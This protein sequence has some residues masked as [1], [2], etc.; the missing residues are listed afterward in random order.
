[1]V[2]KD[3]NNISLEIILNILKKAE[4]H[5]RNIAKD[6]N[7]SHT[8]ILRKTKELVDE[9]VLDYKKQGKNKVF[10]LK[11]TLKAKNY[12]FMAENYKT[13]KVLREY[14]PLGVI[15][16]DV[17]NNAEADLIILFGSYAKFNA[18]KSSDIDLFIETRHNRLKEK[19]KH[20]D[21]RISLKTGRFDQSNN[22]IKEI[23]KNHA[24]IKGIEIFYEKTKFFE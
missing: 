5:A 9:N 12:V 17:I 6:L 7:I 11:K 3:S 18:K 1:M 10:F 15:M 16:K 19:L 4:N 20:I 14:P 24:L 2:Q 21:N 13:N 8:T 23:I 22:L